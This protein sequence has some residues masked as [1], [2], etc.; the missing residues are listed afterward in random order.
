MS[1]P[2]ISQEENAFRDQIIIKRSRSIA[3][4]HPLDDK[5]S[6]RSKD[7]KSGERHHPMMNRNASDAAINKKYVI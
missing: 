2:N 6:S 4:L 3:S 5:K 1:S 7:Q